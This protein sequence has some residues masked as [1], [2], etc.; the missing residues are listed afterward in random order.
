MASAR[1]YDEDMMF[2]Y[3]YIVLL[4][5]VGTGKSTLV[6][7]IS[8]ETGISSSQSTSCTKVS[9]LYESF[10]KRIVICDT[11]GSNAMTD[12]F[13]HNAWIAGAINY[14]PVSR[15]LIC[16]LAQPRIA[17]VIDVVK[18]YLEGKNL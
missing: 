10:D 16:V 15:I 1:T 8:G 3:H 5:D 7:K 9:N 11:P 14:S 4:G 12:K 17:N 2:P 18:K 6:E 13:K